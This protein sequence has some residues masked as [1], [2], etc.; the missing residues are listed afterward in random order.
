VEAPGIESLTTSVRNVANLRD[1]D[2]DQGDARRPKDGLRFR[3]RRR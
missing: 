1:D 3:P 2:A